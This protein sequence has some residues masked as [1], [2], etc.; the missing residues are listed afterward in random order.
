MKK[1]KPRI[2]LLKPRREVIKTIKSIQVPGIVF[3]KKKE[4][5]Y[6]KSWFQA[7]G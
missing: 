1:N 3:I 6:Q 2:S 4:C 5:G 7:N